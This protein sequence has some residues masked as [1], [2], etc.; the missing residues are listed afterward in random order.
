VLQSNDL[1]LHLQPRLL[2]LL[3]LRLLLLLHLL[4]QHLLGY[5]WCWHHG[6]GWRDAQVLLLLLLPSQEFY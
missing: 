5:A 2:L 4:L 6:V 3:L 1:L